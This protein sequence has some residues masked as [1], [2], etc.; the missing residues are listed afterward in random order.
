M[1]ELKKTVQACTKCDLIISKTMKLCKS[2]KK[3]R[4]I[5]WKTFKKHQ[6]Q[7][8]EQVK[9]SLGLRALSA[10]RQSEYVRLT[11]AGRR[12]VNECSVEADC[13]RSWCVESAFPP[14]SCFPRPLGNNSKIATSHPPPTTPPS[15]R[16]G[17]W[18]FP[19]CV[20]CDPT[21]RQLWT[22]SGTSKWLIRFWKNRATKSIPCILWTTRWPTLVNWCSK[23]TYF[24][25]CWHSRFWCIGRSFHRLWPTGSVSKD[26][27]QS[28]WRLPGDRWTC[29]RATRCWK[30]FAMTRCWLRY[31]CR[32]KLSN[33]STDSI[34]DHTRP[35]N[36]PKGWTRDVEQCVRRDG[37]WRPYDSQSWAN[38]RSSL[39]N[40]H[41]KCGLAW[42]AI[43]PIWSHPKC[44]SHR[45]KCRSLRCWNVRPRRRRKCIH[46]RETGPN[47]WCHRR[48]HSTGT[49]RRWVRRRAHC[50]SSS[51]TTANNSRP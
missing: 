30:P 38:R 51:P 7:L 36:G 33:F 14:F 28:L 13:W 1:S 44:E 19:K 16:P 40:W 8:S 12:S 29:R 41:V 2:R 48:R 6:K 50:S 18:T 27:S 26:T 32:R 20:L 34:S 11:R 5:P 9:S 49:V 21:V 10:K 3:E 31:H 39:A 22:N 47:W 15:I 35:A 25:H 42:C 17:S 23:S 24:F 43:S 46:F 37:R 45:S 4:W